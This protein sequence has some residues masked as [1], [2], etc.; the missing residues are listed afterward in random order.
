[1]F[2]I[3]FTVATNWDPKLID[4]LAKYPVSDLY[5]VAEHSIVG[6]GRPS[7]LLTKVTEDDIAEYIKKVHQN[8]MQFSYLL[9]APCMNN[10][11]YDASYHKKLLD[12]ILFSQ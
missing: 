4:E 3:K 12:Y 8:K 2:K 7:F 1:M 11:E 6:G 9:N 10:M 5:G